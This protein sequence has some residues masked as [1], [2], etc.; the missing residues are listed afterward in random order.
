[1]SKPLLAA[2]PGPLSWKNAPVSFRVTGDD[3][4]VIEAGPSTD[5]FVDPA[6]PKWDV[7]SA[8]CA[9]FTPPDREFL[10][11]AKVK[12]P[13]ASTFDAGTIHLRVGEKLWGKLCFEFSPQRNP[14]VVSVVTHG[15][16]DDCNGPTI[17]GSEVYLR[18]AVTP[19]SIAFHYSTDGAFWNMARFFTLGD[20]SGMRVGLSAQSPCGK[21]CEVEFSEIRYRAGRLGDHR[22]G[23]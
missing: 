3:S 16:S 5:W 15:K 8:P 6:D 11:S 14:T 7:D 22:S 18:V 23:D 21:G 12:V 19:E 17:N 20:H 10:L 2:C 9:L 1:M 13:F 4:I